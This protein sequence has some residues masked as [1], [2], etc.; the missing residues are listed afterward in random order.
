M[1]ID[2]TQ[3]KLIFRAM[4]VVQ[5]KLMDEAHKLHES[6]ASDY[7]REAAWKKYNEDN[8]AFTKLQIALAEAFP[9]LV[10]GAA[11]SAG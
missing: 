8:E 3:A 7:L 4:A 11:L 6:E 10:E 1:E 9:A 2:E 5:N